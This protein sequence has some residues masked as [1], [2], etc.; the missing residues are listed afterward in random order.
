A[1]KRQTV[2]TWLYLRKLL[3]AAKNTAASA[4]ADAFAALSVEGK[5]VTVRALRERARVSTDA[6]S[7]WLR[8]NRATRD[9]SPVPADVLAR[10]LDPLWSAAVAAARDEQAE[11]DAAERAALV[12]AEADALTDLAT[13]T[14]RAETA[15][16]PDDATAR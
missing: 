3:M 12:T 6:A 2:R 7:E 14:S 4:L 15:E 11:A 9:V 10:V 16:S 5:P 1:H 8:T 13:A